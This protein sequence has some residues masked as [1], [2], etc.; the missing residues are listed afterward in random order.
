MTRPTGEGEFRSRRLGLAGVL[1]AA[2]LLPMTLGCGNL[3]A[4]G[5]TGETALV[6]AGDAADGD[7]GG[8]ATAAWDFASDA[9]APTSTSPSD[10]SAPARVI[11][12]EVEVVLEAYLISSDGTQVPLSDQAVSASVEISG[13]DEAEAMRREV[14]ADLYPRLRL[15]ISEVTAD[16]RSGLVLDEPLEDDALDI[17]V[18]L[19]QALDVEE[20]VSLDIGDGDAAEILL[21]LNAPVWLETADSLGVVDPDAFESAIEIRIR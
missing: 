11:E 15:V 17:T 21:D 13:E 8:E 18:D 4:G 1:L 20:T 10:A 2:I 19:D 12:G 9:S 14:S 16:I 3:G 5:A 7:G 6:V